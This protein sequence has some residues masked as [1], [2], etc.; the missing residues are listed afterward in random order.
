MVETLMSSCYMPAVVFSQAF[1]R[2]LII[3]KVFIARKENSYD[4]EEL[5]A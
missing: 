1:V 2:W 3:D 5:L 4:R